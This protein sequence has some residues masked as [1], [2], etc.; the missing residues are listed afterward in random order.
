MATNA[1]G[2]FLT[3]FQ[4]WK[5]CPPS[6]HLWTIRIEQFNNGSGNGQTHTFSDLYK[7]ICTANATFENGISQRYKVSGNPDAIN[8]F[9]INSQDNN[10]GLFLATNVSFS[11]NAITL[12]D[13]LSS[14]SIAYS[15][16]INY[17]KALTGKQHN[18]DAK[19]RFYKSNWDINEL[20]IDRWIAAIGRQGLIESSSLP[21]IKGT[22]IISEYAAG[23]P[24]HSSKTWK[25]RKTIKLYKAFPKSRDTIT[26]SYEPGEAGAYKDSL[27][28]FDFSTYEI[29]YGDGVDNSISPTTANPTG[30]TDLLGVVN[31]SQA[32]DGG[33]TTAMGNIATYA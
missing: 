22:I 28:E 21:N 11:P 10:I 29:I 12:A 5:Y 23:F 30:S 19:I 13:Q 9:I 17:G 2:T 18:L 25:L 4:D 32:T 7:A 16:F 3:K 31:P 33:I 15:G 6:D 27:V 26:L 24:G 8:N 1:L 20:L 14:H